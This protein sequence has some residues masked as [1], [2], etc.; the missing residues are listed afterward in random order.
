MPGKGGE[1]LELGRVAWV[2]IAAEL[3]SA[4]GNRCL[5]QMHQNTFASGVFSG[6]ASSLATFLVKKS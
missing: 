4:V 2:N 6:S 3:L 5:K 1:K